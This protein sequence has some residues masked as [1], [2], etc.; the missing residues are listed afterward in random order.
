MVLFE[1]FEQLGLLCAF[2]AD[3]LVTV[4]DWDEERRGLSREL[5]RKRFSPIWLLGEQVGTL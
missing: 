5:T 4:K 3:N 1:L 2:E